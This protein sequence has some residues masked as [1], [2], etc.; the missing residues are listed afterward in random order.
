M[1]FIENG[2]ANLDGGALYSTSL[3]QF[4]LSNGSQIVFDGNAGK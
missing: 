4:Q 2:N 3:G 1:Y